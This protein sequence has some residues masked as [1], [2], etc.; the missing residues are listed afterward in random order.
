MSFPLFRAPNLSATCFTL[1]GK[2]K[3]LCAATAYVLSSSSGVKP[4]SSLAI[5]LRSSS[6]VSVV[7]SM[8]IL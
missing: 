1:A 3:F 6:S 7:S 8:R 4:I 5:A 2:G